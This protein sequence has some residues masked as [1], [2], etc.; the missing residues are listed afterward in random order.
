[1]ASAPEL[2]ASAFKPKT[3]V[4]GTLTQKGRVVQTTTT[5]IGAKKPGQTRDWNV[6]P[7][8]AWDENFVMGDVPEGEYTI[9]VSVYGQRFTK[10]VT[11]NA[12]TTA[13]VT[14]GPELPATPQPVQGGS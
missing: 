8:P 9:T 14:L 11:V 4:D 12:A 13:F 6:V 7:D 10:Q 3:F 2:D 1:M 5:Y